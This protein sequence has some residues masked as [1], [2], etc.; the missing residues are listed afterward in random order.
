M[1]WSEEPREATL[2]VRA[3]VRGYRPTPVTHVDVSHAF[4]MWPRDPSHWEKCHVICMTM[5]VTKMLDQWSNPIRYTTR[6][7]TVMVHD[8]ADKP[9]LYDS[10]Y[11]R[12]R[13]WR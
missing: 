12:L 4:R 9:F 3:S 1:N 2:H 7:D 6:R 11:D 5:F 8:C 10:L 13:L